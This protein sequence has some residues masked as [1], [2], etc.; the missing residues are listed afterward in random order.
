MKL[1]PTLWLALALIAILLSACGASNAATT[2]TLD[3]TL[4]YTQAAQTVAAQFTQTSAAL[5]AS[6]PTQTNTPE[7]TITMA[8]TFT[9]IATINFFTQQP[10]STQQ[11]PAGVFTPTFSI[12]PGAGTP[13]VALCN[14][15]AYVRDVGVVDG[16]KLKPGQ[17][18]DKGWHIINT[19]SCNWGIGYHLVHVGGNTNFGGDTFTI[20]FPSDVVLPGVIAEISLHL[21][22]PNKPGKYEARYQMYSNQD[23]PFGTGLTVA[24]EVQK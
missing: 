7:P 18:F 13:T 9:P 6:A 19:G 10:G 3:G 15:S 17:A 2:P 8:P 1:T 24:I 21:V 23:I 4:V 5:T 14:D 11:P 20:R 22:A 16:T 12:I